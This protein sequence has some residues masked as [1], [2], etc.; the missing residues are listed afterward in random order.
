METFVRYAFAGLWASLAVAMMA[1]IA[2]MGA[3]R[4]G[5]LD[6]LIN[7]PLDAYWVFGGAIA[8]ALFLRSAREAMRP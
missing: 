3:A 8:V 1:K 4:S 5:P 2:A 7:S 6:S